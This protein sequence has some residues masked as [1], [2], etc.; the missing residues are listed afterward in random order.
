[1]NTPT[2]M[3]AS[4]RATQRLREIQRA[5]CELVMAHGYDGFT[6]TQ[7]ADAVGVSRRTL[8]N[9]VPDKESA[10]LGPAAPPDHPAVDTFRT[11]GPSGKLIPDL[12]AV[13]EAILADEVCGDGNPGEIHQLLE[14]AVAAD[15]K[16]AALVAQ[17]F[18]TM[19]DLLAGL[20]SERQGWPPGDLRSRTFAAVFFALV[21]VA[22]DEVAAHPDSCDFLSA[23]RDALEALDELQGLSE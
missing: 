17:R 7:L 21:K 22:L 5:A 12:V 13:M 18:Q 19:A 23:F 10:V 20:M 14:R 4:A 15:G 16:V 1:M 2:P 9:Y 6:M 8:F 11:H 3:A